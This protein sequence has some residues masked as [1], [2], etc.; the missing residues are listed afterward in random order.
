MSTA[1]VA[2]GSNLGD[3]I[4]HLVS[5]R[6]A[7]AALADSVEASPIFE[8]APLGP[9]QPAYLN[10]VLRLSFAQTV[11]AHALLDW[12]LQTER[13]ALRV[14]GERFGPRTLDVDL[15]TL[16]DVV[17]DT[18]SLVL[19]HP[20]MLER[21]FVLAPLAVLEPSYAPALARVG[22]AGIERFTDPR[23]RLRG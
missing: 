7:A 23:W 21:A 10:A 18:P 20:R 14:R 11:D 4:A 22:T 13:R 15:L 9:P 1:F 12:A 3:R 6:D 16:D 19:P 5:A 8:T 2:L 17:L